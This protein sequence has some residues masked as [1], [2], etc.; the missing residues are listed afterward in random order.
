MNAH[1][2]L[3]TRVLYSAVQGNWKR[4]NFLSR[5]TVMYRWSYGFFVQFGIN[6]HEWGSQVAS[7]IAISASWKTLKSKV[8]LN[9]TRKTVWLVI[10]NINIKRFACRKSQKIFLE[11]IFFSFEKLELFSN[12]HTKF[13]ISLR[14]I[15]GSE[16][17]LLSF[18]QSIII[19]NYD[20]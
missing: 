4:L 5:F 17:F 2:H 7:E 15:I 19:Q 18:A 1:L 14:D 16:N 6:L 20:V 10:K 8:I 13:L 9:W 3:S 11:A 12:F